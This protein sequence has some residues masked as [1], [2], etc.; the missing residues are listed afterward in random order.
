M[1]FRQR[2]YTI[3]DNFEMRARVGTYDQLEM[4]MALAFNDRRAKFYADTRT[5]GLIFFNWLSDRE[6]SHLYRPVEYPTSTDPKNP[7][8]ETYIIKQFNEP[9]SVGPAIQYAKQWLS[10]LT[11][12]QFEKYAGPHEEFWDMWSEPGALVCTGENWTHIGTH[13]GGICYVKPSWM[14]I[15]K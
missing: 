8:Y 3:A 4:A 9:K 2:R 10:A 14:M 15:G 5:Y 1:E 11:K 13:T 6:E 12:S 7:S